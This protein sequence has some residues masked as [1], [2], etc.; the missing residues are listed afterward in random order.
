MIYITLA[1]EEFRFTEERSLLIGRAI[2]ADIRPANPYVSRR[3]GR[4]APTPGGW[5]Y[6]D[7]GGTHG[8]FRAG[9]RVN[10]LVL[11]GP[12]TLLLGKPGLGAEIHIHPQH[13]SRIFICYRRGDT[14]GHAGRLR[15]QLAETF[16]DSQIFL[17]IDNMGI[18]EDFRER[19]TRTIA[20]CK[21]VIVVIGRGWASIQDDLGRRRL[22][23]DDDSVRL[24]VRAAL[25]HAPRVKVIPVLVQGASMPSERDLPRDLHQL[26]RINGLL[27]PDDHWRH[28]MPRLVQTL[29]E[30]MRSG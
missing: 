30:I 6:E 20:S 8:T 28:E 14:S 11:I 21:A 17:D 4:L 24:E 16:G 29:E 15:D 26:T 9:A 18:G 19:V 3:H 2:D 10:R 12:T 13:D 27:L 1:G 5:V 23:E 7:L 22:S 25:R